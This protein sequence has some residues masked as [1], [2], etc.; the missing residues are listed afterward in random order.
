M[1][2]TERLRAL[3]A[4]ELPSLV[5]LR[6]DLHAH[7]ETAFEERRTSEV[8]QRELVAAG[9]EHRGG[10]ARGTGVL[11]HIP[12]EGERATALRAD[13]D[14]LPITEATG[15]AWWPKPFAPCEPRSR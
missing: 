6:R 11:A 1:P 7:P 9:I 10:L 14:A 5:A 15:A 13:M 2:T 12:A 4:Q 8:V 3:I